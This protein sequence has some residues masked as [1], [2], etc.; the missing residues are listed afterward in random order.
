MSSIIP[1]EEI[2]VKEKVKCSCGSTVLLK[3]LKSH[4]KTQKHLSGGVV[5]R[6]GEKRDRSDTPVA[7]VSEDC[8]GNLKYEKLSP[9]K[10]K[11]SIIKANNSNSNNDDDGE[12]EELPFEE[13]VLEELD[14]INEKLD[15]I[16]QLIIGDGN[17][18]SI[19]EGNE[20]NES[21]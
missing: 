19:D 7:R 16:V 20:K 10:A 13:E 9:L 15:A 21:S 6:K 2:S 8:I 4:E 12:D 17:L 14:N 1:E 18:S 3:N 11:V 5:S